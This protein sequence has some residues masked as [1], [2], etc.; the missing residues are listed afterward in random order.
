MG[1]VAKFPFS[2]SLKILAMQCGGFTKAA[3]QWG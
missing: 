1:M 3:S 2:D